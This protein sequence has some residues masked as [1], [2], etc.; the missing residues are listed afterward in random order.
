MKKMLIATISLAVLLAQTAVGAEA[1]GVRN[2][3]YTTKAGERVLRIETVVPASVEQVW[4]VWTTQEG[5]REWIA[6]VVAID[7]PEQNDGGC[8]RSFRF[9]GHL[10]FFR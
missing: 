3:S 7:L 1:Q 5:L 6:P 8:S 4:N 2:T 9:A 10:Q